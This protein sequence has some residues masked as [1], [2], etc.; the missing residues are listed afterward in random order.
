MVGNVDWEVVVALVV[1]GAAVVEAEGRREG[2]HGDGPE[3][4]VSHEG[5]AM[6]SRERSRETRMRP[7]RLAARQARV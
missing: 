6:A 3:M 4:K 5:S 7:W 2:G 1:L